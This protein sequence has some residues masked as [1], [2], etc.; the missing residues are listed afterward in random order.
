[1]PCSISDFVTNRR[2]IIIPVFHQRI[3]KTYQHP[4]AFGIPFFILLTPEEACSYD[5]IVEKIVEKYEQFIGSKKILRSQEQQNVPRGHDTTVITEC[6]QQQSIENDFKKEKDPYDDFFDLKYFS[7]RHSVLPTGW[8]VPMNHL[9]RLKTRFRKDAVADKSYDDDTLLMMESEDEPF[10]HGTPV[11]LDDMIEDSDFSI[12]KDSSDDDLLPANPVSEKTCHVSL[13]QEHRLRS[14]SDINVHGNKPPKNGKAF[15][16]QGEAIVC[17]WSSDYYTSIFLN[18][19]KNDQR[20]G[21]VWDDVEKYEDSLLSNDREPSTIRLD[22]CLDLFSKKE[23]LGEDDLWY[24]PN[25]K[26]H[27]RATKQL[28]IWK[29]PDILVIHLK[30]FSSSR[31]LRDKIDVLVDFPLKGLDLSERVAGNKYNSS[32]ANDSQI[33][34]LYA[35]SNHFGGLGG[36][37]YTAYVILEDGHFY[38]FDVNIDS[39]VVRVHESQIVTPAAYLLFYRRRTDKALG[40]STM[41]KITEYISKI[42]TEPH[43]K[44]HTASSLN[45]VS[46]LAMSDEKFIL[47]SRPISMQNTQSNMIHIDLSIRTPDD[48]INSN[49]QDSMGSEKIAFSDRF[50]YND[51]E[52]CLN[53]DASI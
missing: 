5:L 9:P 6:L 1:M 45:K 37:H 40:G 49:S 33:Y 3:E 29:S 38:H 35:V 39:L 14:S 13:K 30:R 11:S 4:I 2:K 8:S 10:S 17:E 48:S 19:V 7:S 51:K 21:T 50:D 43:D 41:T 22:D 52:E 24:C 23:Q 34:D 47:D 46:D 15:I 27:R 42:S 53:S 28:E 36:G 32:L 26:E 31:N 16:R 25:C 20:Y 18:E 12:T 44:M